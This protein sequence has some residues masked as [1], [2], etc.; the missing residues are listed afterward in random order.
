MQSAQKI[1][2]VTLASPLPLH[3]NTSTYIFFPDG[4]NT[5]SYYSWIRKWMMNKTT[6]V[7]HKWRIFASLHAKYRFYESCWLLLLL[8][9][10]LVFL[11]DCIC[12]KCRKRK[13]RRF[14]LIHSQHRR[15][16][17]ERLQKQ[18]PGRTEQPRTNRAAKERHKPVEQLLLSSA[19]LISCVEGV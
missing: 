8:E 15:F 19:L 3:M 10:T 5:Y 2:T 16:Y 17:T 6:E 18:I 13:S 11:C 9:D 14:K 1:A 4:R 12:H 7:R